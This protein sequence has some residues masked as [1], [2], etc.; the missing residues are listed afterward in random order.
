MIWLH[1]I[2]FQLS[3]GFLQLPGFIRAFWWHF[4]P[5]RCARQGRVR[6]GPSVWRVGGGGE[7]ACFFGCVTRFLRKSSGLDLVSQETCSPTLY[8]LSL[9][10]FRIA[11]FKF[12]LGT[13]QKQLRNDQ[14]ITFHEN[15]DVHDEKSRQVVNILG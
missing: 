13:L 6:G 2:T 12:N 3:D 10:K 9:R 8:H 1:Y 14:I 11:H 15:R 5:S 7:N 4:A